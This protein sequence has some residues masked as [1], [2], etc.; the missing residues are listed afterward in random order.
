M[1][2]RTATY[3]EQVG[4]FMSNGVARY[5]LDP[6]CECGQDT[7][8]V[9]DYSVGKIKCQRCKKVIVEKFEEAARFT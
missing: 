9:D 3:M 6:P 2:N 4:I 5:K 7:V 8:I 1:Q